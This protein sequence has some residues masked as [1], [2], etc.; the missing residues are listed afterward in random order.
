[1]NCKLRFG[2]CLCT[3]ALVSALVAAGC[4]SSSKADSPATSSSSTAP[5]G[6]GTTAASASVAA[7]ITIKDIMF[8]GPITVKPG[9]TV[10][11]KNDD[12]TTH[13]LASDDSKLFD[14]GN[15]FAGV[16]MSFVAPKVAGTY[17]FHCNIHANMHGVLTVS[18]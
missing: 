6:A 1:M 14:T 16:T 11:V 5:R 12:N 15:I 18:A 4:G 3:L 17:K 9:T 2:S 8:S 13:T 10:I 7:T